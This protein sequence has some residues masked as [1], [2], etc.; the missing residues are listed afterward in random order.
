[1]KKYKQFIS[2]I[3]VGGLL[4]SGGNVLANGTALPTITNWVKYKFNG[5]EKALPSG[6]TTLN[7]EGHTYVPAR[8]IAEELGAE[9]KW[10]DETKSVSID[11]PVVEN[12]QEND[13]S[14]V[15]DT[16]VQ[17]L[18]KFEE[19]PVSKTIDGV[20][21]ELYSI[22]E[23]QQYTKFYVV[24]KNTKNKLVQLDQESAYFQSE[25]DTYENKDVAGVLFWKDKSWF[26]DIGEDDEF[27]GYIMLPPIPN[28]EKS[29]KFS[30]EL[31]EN[32]LNQNV[33]KYDFDIKW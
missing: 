11:K 22:E 21:V 33:M 31:F 23:N 20:R 24:V 5:E 18:N 12:D 26:G 16:P 29:G 17:D 30:V 6:Y 32:G 9:V 25:F 3:I 8:F 28:D 19:L 13:N 27:E 2:G 14:E 15:I 4:L 1:M 7:Y 10:D